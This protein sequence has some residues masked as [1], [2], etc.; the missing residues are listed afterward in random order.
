MQSL[1]KTTS[2]VGVRDAINVLNAL[3]SCMDFTTTHC[4]CLL[5]AKWEGED[6]TI[7]KQP[8]NKTEQKNKKNKTGASLACVWVL[9]QTQRK[10]NNQWVE[11]TGGS[12]EACREDQPRAALQTF[13]NFFS[14]SWSET[15]PSIIFSCVHV[16]TLLT[17]NSSQETWLHSLRCKPKSNQFTH[18]HS[19]CNHT[20]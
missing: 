20:N 16:E 14:S 18:K 4:W 2:A 1:D 10:Q 17:L 11:L 3:I 12:L 5:K 19:S 13:H 15:D 7:R 6:E 8:Y 9:T